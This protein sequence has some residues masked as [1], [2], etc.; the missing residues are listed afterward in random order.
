VR[1]QFDR[2]R[3]ERGGDGVDF[4]CLTSLSGLMRR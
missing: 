2:D 1:L 3:A 4:R